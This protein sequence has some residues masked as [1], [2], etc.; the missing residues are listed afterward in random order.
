VRAI[1]SP[2][3]DRLQRL[4][5]SGWLDVVWVAFAAANLVAMALV[6]QWETVP[7]HFIWVSLTLVY[8]YRVWESF[9]TAPR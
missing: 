8:G 7:F 4:L 1:E 3:R 5:A 9:Q 6:P 2:V